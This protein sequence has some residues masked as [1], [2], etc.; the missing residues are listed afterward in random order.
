MALQEKYAEVINTANRA[1]VSNLQVREQDNVLYV[2]GDAPSAAV[3]DQI[4]DVYEKLD[5][6]FR[7]ADMVLNI[8]VS[9]SEGSTYE[10]KA[11]DSLSKIGK[12]LGKSWQEIYEA[13]RAVIGNNPD[14]IKPGQMLQIP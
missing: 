14:L 11:G 5:P 10:V 8:N 1:G 4:W 6:D 9:S 2:D 13:N 7:S 3:K 12:R